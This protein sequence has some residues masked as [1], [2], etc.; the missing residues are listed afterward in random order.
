MRELIIP[1]GVDSDPDATEMVRFW[2]AD[3]EPHVS[4]LLGMYEDDKDCDIGELYAWG[5]I[6]RDIAQHVAHGLQKSHG[7]DFDKSARTI[8]RHF[9]DAMAERSPGLQGEYV[10]GDD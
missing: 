5:H 2:L 8:A 7:W 4:L 3:G 10:D 9:A 6:L 1:V